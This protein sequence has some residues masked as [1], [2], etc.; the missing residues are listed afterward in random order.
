MQEKENERNSLQQ[1]IVDDEIKQ[2]KANYHI[3]QS[4]I[5]DI[6]ISADKLAL[7]AEKHKTFTYLTESNEKKKICKAKNTEMEELKLSEN[8]V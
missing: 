6:A 3:L 2:I 8:V 7:K 1:K 4:E 5:E